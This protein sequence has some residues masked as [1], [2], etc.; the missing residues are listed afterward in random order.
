MSTA[1][2]SQPTLDLVAAAS[3]QALTHSPKLHDSPAPQSAGAF[4]C[5]PSSLQDWTL[6]E[7]A[8]AT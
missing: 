8:Q 7:S 5:V 1:Q 2:N 3:S 6:S 4:H